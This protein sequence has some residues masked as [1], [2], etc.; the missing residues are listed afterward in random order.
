MATLS[1]VRT[2]VDAWLADKWPVLVARQ[3]T[4]FANHG[5]YWQG[6]RTHTFDLNHTSQTDG[7]SSPDNLN[8]RP[9]DVE[10]SWTTLFPA[11]EGVSIPAVLKVDVYD[12]PL[13][14]G[15]VATVWVAYNGT[16]YRRSR[17][18]GPW[19]ERT[20]AWAVAEP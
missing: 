15:W 18:V 16:V 2:R 3:E 20:E 19:T 12:G 10:E 8:S 13:G 11:W 1:Q 17:N 5:H 6:V 7:D 4:Y 14:K 9:T